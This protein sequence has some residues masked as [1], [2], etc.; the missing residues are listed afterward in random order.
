MIP[1]R[2]LVYV[3]VSGQEQGR[4]GTSLDGQQKAA[5]SYCA[6]R[7][8]PEPEFFVEV[9]SAG[10]E[11]IERRSE[12]RRLLHEVK[13][14]DTVVVAALDRW[15][16]DI[17]F[18]VQSVRELVARKIGWISIV[19]NID[20]STS[21]GDSTLG[22]MAWVADGERKRIRERTVGRKRE[23]RA[24]GK[25]VEGRLPYGY[26]RS[27]RAL[28][29]YEP[30]AA[31]VR[32][33]F[34]MC[35]AGWSVRE[36]AEEL[37]STTSERWEGWRVHNL[38][39][40][41]IYLGEISTPDGKVTVHR[42]HEA[43]VDVS[44]FDRAQA[45]MQKRRQGHHKIGDPSARTRNWL[46]FG[47]AACA[48][49]GAR[50]GSAYGN[51]IDYYVC[52]NRRNR[53][54]CRAAYVRVDAADAMAALQIEQHLTELRHALART[55]SSAKEQAS[56]R[57][58][59][60]A[61]RKRCE[62]RAKRATQLAVDG[63]LSPAE[64]REQKE[65]IERELREIDAEEERVKRAEKATAP[66]ARRALLERVDVLRAVWARMTA[67]ERS[68][69]L[70][71]LASEVRLTAGASPE[72]VWRTTGELAEEAEGRHE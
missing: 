28:A 41:R 56:T 25:Y 15:S 67:P 31:I 18:A 68:R 19:D 43:I 38:L 44:T 22:I 58:S 33:A 60:E 1:N 47:I 52:C 30:E 69:V 57:A 51:G 62:D 46:M 27:G 7:G 63:L 4:H 20:A 21:S 17:V 5:Q 65:R 24:E 50:M 71:L 32:E 55:G 48:I 23:L 13:P 53:G 11:K 66:E 8:W 39:T 59:V 12:L 72:I 36:I 34:R 9:E 16:R 29:L 42:T 54:E 49:C 35:N 64:L 2:V 40:N 61:K 6:L 37:A 10:A 14:G 26:H 70:G 3:R 45:A